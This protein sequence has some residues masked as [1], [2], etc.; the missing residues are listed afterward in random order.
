MKLSEKLFQ[1]IA[2]EL[3]LSRIVGN[4]G[5]VCIAFYFGTELQLRGYVGAWTS[6]I[7]WAAGLLLLLLAFYLATRKRRNMKDPEWV[8]RQIAFLRDVEGGWPD[9]ALE[10]A[11]EIAKLEDGKKRREEGRHGETRDMKAEVIAWWEANKHTGISKNEAAEQ[12]VKLVPLSIV[13]IR[14]HLKGLK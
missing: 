10:A 8:A 9:P 4:L 12:M 2:A 5:I 6:V 14:N 1:Q 3:S 13:T 7:S 11:I